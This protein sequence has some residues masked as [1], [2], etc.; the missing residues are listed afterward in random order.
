V[1]QQASDLSEQ[2]ASAGIK[3]REE[4]HTFGWFYSMSTWLQE[5]CCWEFSSSSSHCK[6]QLASSCGAGVKSSQE[7]CKDFLVG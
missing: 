4:V 3:H 5:L 6:A 1:Q 2:R 7:S